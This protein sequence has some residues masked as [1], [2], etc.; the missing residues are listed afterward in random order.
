[1]TKLRRSFTLKSVEAKQDGADDVVRIAISTESP[2]L[3]ARLNGHKAAYEVLGHNPNE[4]K[5][6][7]MEDGAPFLF[8]HKTDTQIGVLENVSL[9]SDGVMRADVRFSRSQF[10]QE[11]LDDIKRGIRKRISVGYEVLE[12]KDAGMADDGTPLV[13]ATQWNPYEASLVSIPADLKAGVGRAF[14]GKKEGN[15]ATAPVFVYDE[16][17]NMTEIILPDGTKI[18]D[19]AAIQAIAAQYMGAVAQEAEEP[20]TED[21]VEEVTEE[22]VED[23][24]EDAVEVE[25]V[26]AVEEEKNEEGPSDEL[27]S[28]DSEDAELLMNAAEA[29]TPIED[30]KMDE[31]TNKRAASIVEL[32]VRHGQAEKAAEWIASGKTVEDVKDAL[33]EV[34]SNTSKIGTPALHL[35]NRDN[36]VASAVRAFLQ[37][38]GSEL[39][40]R[41][42]DAARKAGVTINPNALYLPH[43]VPMIRASTFGNKMQVRTT[44]AGATGGSNGVGKEF[45]TWEE[46]LREGSLLDRVGGQVLT[47]NDV[48]SMPYFSAPTT[49]SLFAETGSVSTQAA[50]VAARNWTPKRIAARYEFSNLLGRLNGTYDFESE[51]Y[52][53]LLAEGARIF[54]QQVWGGTGANNQILGISNDTNV[55]QYSANSGSFTLAN[56]G[57]MVTVLAN[58]NANIDNAVFVLAHDVYNSAYSTAVFGTGSG[59]SVLDIVKNDRQVFRTGY[60]AKPDAPQSTAICGDFS[61]VTAAQFGPLVITRDELTALASGKTILN[62]EMFADSV[63]RQ[64]ASLVRWTRVIV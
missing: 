35:K 60:V 14:S 8:E 44:Y 17:E 64:P 57:G 37:A 6:D 30:D 28:T 20:V 5:M 15:P 23:A 53:D 9:D 50:V 13:R 24:V 18:T 29:D 56:A 48:A 4:V 61:K 58:N 12:Y 16:D 51:L 34:R 31:M 39:A 3:R 40:E 41:G 43:D 25:S 21:I 45:L 1:M 11:M 62:L 47:L 54:D 63:V 19:E 22:F 2:Y 55:A 52:N 33:L 10:A 46:A 36:D 27:E 42:I 7:Y 38:D 32:A 59:N 26:D 49:A